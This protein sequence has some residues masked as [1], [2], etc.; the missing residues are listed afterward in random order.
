MKMKPPVVIEA[1]KRAGQSI[2]TPPRVYLSGLNP[3]LTAGK[4]TQDNR[5]SVAAGVAS[6]FVNGVNVTGG[7]SG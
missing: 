1:W 4:Q 5:F 7:P 6:T 2:L 3:V